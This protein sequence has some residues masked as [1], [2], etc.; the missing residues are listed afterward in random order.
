M[1]WFVC[2]I[3][4]SHGAIRISCC[5]SSRPLKAGVCPLAVKALKFLAVL[6]CQL[7]GDFSLD[8]G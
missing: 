2:F 8:V 6:C 5:L 3:G 4:V 7:E 1:A